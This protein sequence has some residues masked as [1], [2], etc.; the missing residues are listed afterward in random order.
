V[1]Q[2]LR[3]REPVRATLKVILEKEVERKS[4]KKRKREKIDLRH[5]DDDIEYAILTYVM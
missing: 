5:V 2:Y 4:V 1:Q 3:E